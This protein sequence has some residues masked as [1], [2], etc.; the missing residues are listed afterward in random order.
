MNLITDPWIPVVRLSGARDA[1]RPGQIADRDDPPMSFATGRPDFDGALVQLLIALLQTVETPAS[2]TAWA[3]WYEESPAPGELDELL[4]PL[5]DAFEIDGDGP[6]FLQ[7]LELGEGLGDPT[8]IGD[9]LIDLASG[10]SNDHFLK[11]VGVAALC[12]ACAAMA[13]QTLQVNAPSGGRGHRTGIRG[14]GPM[15]T[16]V[17]PDPEEEPGRDTVWHLVWLNVLDRHDLTKLP[18]GAS[19]TIDHTVLPWLAPTRTSEK[20]SGRPSTPDDH[21]AVHT[22]WAMPRRIRLAPAENGTCGLCAAD[23]LVYRS[24][25]R[26]PYGMSYEGAWRHPFSPYN[27]SSQ[28]PSPV[29]VQPGGVG[30]RQWLAVVFGRDD[31]KN[32]I[33]RA[34]V[35]QSALGRY[36]A[37]EIG[38]VRLWAFGYDTDN[39]KARCWYDETMPITT[40]LDGDP[41]RLDV[42]REAAKAM[43]DT[44]WQ[45]GNNLTQQL[46]KAWQGRRKELKGDLAFVRQRF[47]QDTEA[48]FFRVLVKAGAGGATDGP[49]TEALRAWHREIDRASLAIF[50]AL[51]ARGDIGKADPGVIATARVGLFRFNRSKSIKS[52]LAL[53]VADAST[54]A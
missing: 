14:G 48:A 1:I 3:G 9:L 28:P 15:T 6:R 38:S 31:G 44:A 41:T 34:A 25:L 50:D 37:L 33:S 13:L 40:L 45:V 20:G 35:V 19:D 5:K 2:S 42:L 29:H 51:A 47:W 21:P 52:L 24:Y 46:R 23:G 22:L 53:D 11:D 54:V 32:V 7:D 26:R 16:L 43:I 10:G 12:P 27:E 30:Y 39:A 36:D 17:V 8:P 4:R 49:E 18:G